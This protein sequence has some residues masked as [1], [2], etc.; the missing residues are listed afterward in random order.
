MLNRPLLTFTSAVDLAGLS[1]SLWLGF[2]VLTRSSRRR[3][4]WLAI[5]TL[6]SLS[7]SFLDSLIHI[8]GSGQPRDLPWWWG[9][10]VA[11]AVP[12]WY[13][14]TVSL[15][16]EKLGKTRRA[17][18]LP[19]YFLAVNFVAMQA[20]GPW[21]FPGTTTSSPLYY[22]S[23]RAGIL[24]PLYVVFLIVIPV[25][26]LYNLGQLWRRAE[27]VILQ[28]RFATLFWATLAALLS[29]VYSAVSIGFRL[30]TPIVINSLGLGTAVGL[31]GYGV[32]RYN[33]LLE[34]RTIGRDFPYTLLAIALV[35]VAYALTAVTSNLVFDA[36]FVAFIF[37]IVL[38]IVTH[39]LYDWGRSYLDRHVYR[40]Q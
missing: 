22:S 26:S 11:P 34:G 38:A 39:S 10:S 12:L 25:L 9:W 3:L 30:D 24:Y 40:R 28:R 18:V 19:F 29:A 1:L 17:L 6:W 16:P 23:Q 35:V 36:P 4:S 8:H 27:G 32:A 33:A 37:I 20:Y 5:A 31:L 2:Y 14:L 13:H 21:I 7:G 15:Q